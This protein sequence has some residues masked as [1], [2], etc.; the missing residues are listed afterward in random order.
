V[1]VVVQSALEQFRKL[2]S[3]VE[4]LLTAAAESAA[5]INSGCVAQLVE[6]RSPK[7]PVG[8]SNPSALDADINRSM[9]MTVKKAHVSKDKNPTTSSVNP[10]EFVGEVKGEFHKI[11]WTAQ[12]ELRVYTKVVVACTFVFGIAIYCMDVVIQSVLFG[13]NW[14]MGGGI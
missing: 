9:V 7:S 3:K 1:K 13:L 8:G 10:F 11:T 6:Q 5:V 12:D 14:V 2:S 4:S